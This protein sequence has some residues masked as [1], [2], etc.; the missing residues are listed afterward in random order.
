MDPGPKATGSR[1]AG[2]ETKTYCTSS[3]PAVKNQ[4]ALRLAQ[5]LYRSFLGG[6]LQLLAL[7][8]GRRL[9]CHVDL[10]LMLLLLVLPRASPQW[11]GKQRVVKH[12]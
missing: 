2:N 12:R 11:V 1:S 8:K 10:L 6:Q 7:H 4:I 5:T 9:G 3:S